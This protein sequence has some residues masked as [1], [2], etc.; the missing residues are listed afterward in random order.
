MCAH[1]ISLLPLQPRAPVNFIKDN[2]CIYLSNSSYTTHL[3]RTCVCM[4]VYVCVCACVWYEC[5]DGEGGVSDG[6]VESMI[7]RVGTDGDGG[8]SH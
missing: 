4:C 1:N 5:S 6:R 3:H 7:G 8:V 2:V